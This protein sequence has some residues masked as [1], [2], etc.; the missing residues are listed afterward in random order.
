MT[1]IIQHFI[2]SLHNELHPPLMESSVSGVPGSLEHGDKRL[3]AKKKKKDCQ[4]ICINFIIS[5][6]PGRR[7]N[8]ALA[9]P[10]ASAEKEFNKGSILQLF[11]VIFTQ[12]L[13]LHQAALTRGLGIQMHQH[14]Y[15]KTTG[16]S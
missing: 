14:I 1:L 2:R 13:M 11:H 4:S 12:A 5:S 3:N 9:P 8:L 15:M 6:M 7:S 16:L 10:G